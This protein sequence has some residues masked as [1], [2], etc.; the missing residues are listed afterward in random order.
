MEN[1]VI[2]YTALQ[3]VVLRDTAI[4]SL[5]MALE[6]FEYNALTISTTL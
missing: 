6:D 5:G 2:T 1:S 3:Y 4:C